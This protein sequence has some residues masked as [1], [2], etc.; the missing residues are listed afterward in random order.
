MGRECCRDD[1][2]DDDRGEEIEVQD[3]SADSLRAYS[4]LNI[5]YVW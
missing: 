2:D 5:D 4:Q 3:C 1:D